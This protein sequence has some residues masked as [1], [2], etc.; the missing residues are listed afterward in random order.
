MLPLPFHNSAPEGL[1][2]FLAGGRLPFLQS[3]ELL[4]LGSWPFLLEE[5][6]CTLLAD[7]IRTGSL[8]RLTSLSITDDGALLEV[9]R[10]AFDSRAL[11][12]PSTEA[13]GGNLEGDDGND[14]D[15]EQGVGEEIEEGDHS[16]HRQAIIRK[17][18]VRMRNANYDGVVALL[19]VSFFGRLECLEFAVGLWSNEA[20]KQLAALASYMRGTQGYAPSLRQLSI[21]LGL[22]GRT[23]GPLLPLLMEGRPSGLKHLTLTVLGEG[24]MEELGEI[25]MVEGLANLTTLHIL[26]SQHDD[27]AIQAWMEGVLASEHRGAA[28][29][30]LQVSG[31][32]S[33]ELL[34]GLHCGAFPQLESLSICLG[35]FSMLNEFAQAMGDDGAPCAQTLRFLDPGWCRCRREEYLAALHSS[36]LCACCWP[37]QGID[38]A[39]RCLTNTGTWSDEDTTKE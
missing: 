7:A 11:L 19:Q 4:R 26:C 38:V 14:D 1:A 9:L 30:E 2:L 12:Q 33:D 36:D 28:M 20:E 6:D 8:P 15:D 31:C 34:F 35:D 18:V 22:Q 24:G 10:A 39:V 5:S 3:L 32:D 25:Y 27:E 29:R 21:H 37:K 16:H 13:S 23:F 17:L